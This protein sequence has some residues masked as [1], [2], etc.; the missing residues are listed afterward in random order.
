MT[1]NYGLTLIAAIAAAVLPVTTLRAETPG[2][3]FS[4]LAFEMADL[5]GDGQIDEAE[6]VNDAITGFVAVDTD[7]SGAI[8]ADEAGEG[9]LGSAD[10][11]GDGLLTLQEVMERKLAQ[12]RAADANGDGV[13]SLEETIAH[14]RAN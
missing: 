1:M 6:L 14:D 10:A 9:G 12:M 11:D 2:D 3:D 5:N 13:L 8:A 7:G 4:R